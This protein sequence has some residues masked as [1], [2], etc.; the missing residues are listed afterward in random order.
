MK[1]SWVKRQHSLGTMSLMTSRL[2]RTSW[3]L[4]GAVVPY[5]LVISRFGWP[6]SNLTKKAANKL[7][8]DFLWI[9]MK[10]IWLKVLSI[11]FGIN[12]MPTKVDRWIR[13]KP[14]IS[15]MKFSQ[16]KARAHPAWRN[17]M[18]FLLNMTSRKMG[19]SK[20]KKW[21]IL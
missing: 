13:L 4:R 7:A 10:R 20:K 3:S 5:T 1:I 2:L 16:Y 11:K 18:H 19:Y 6:M 21:P 9:L 8:K 12:T 15:W 14:L 17:L